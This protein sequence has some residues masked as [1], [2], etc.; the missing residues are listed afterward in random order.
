[1]GTPSP[2]LTWLGGGGGRYLGIGTSCGQTESITFHHLSDA[3]GKYCERRLLLR[4][5]SGRK[6]LERIKTDYL[7]QSGC[8]PVLEDALPSHSIYDFQRQLCDTIFMEAFQ[9]SK[10]SHVADYNQDLFLEQGKR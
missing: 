10:Y 6:M 9:S 2:V 8:A 3:V 1:M 4:F 5:L 7:F